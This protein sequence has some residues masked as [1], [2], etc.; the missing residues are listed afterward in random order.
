MSR[1]FRIELFGFE[2]YMIESDNSELK[3]ET[4]LVVGLDLSSSG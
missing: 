2:I 1:T 3:S 4:I